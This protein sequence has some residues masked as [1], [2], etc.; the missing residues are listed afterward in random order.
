MASGT[1]GGQKFWIW[2]SLFARLMLRG[3]PVIIELS[4]NRQTEGLSFVAF[5]FRITAAKN[6]SPKRLAMRTVICYGCSVF[7]AFSP[8]VPPGLCSFLDRF[9]GVVSCAVRQRR[10]QIR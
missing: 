5:S 7:A 9:P 4:V 8:L 10:F 3:T 6:P 1:I 2:T